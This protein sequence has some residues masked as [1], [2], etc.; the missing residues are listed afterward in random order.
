MFLKKTN[1]FKLKKVKIGLKP[2][3]YFSSTI[4]NDNYFVELSMKEFESYYKSKQERISNF[5]NEIGTKFYSERNIESY[6]KKKD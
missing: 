3:R 6:K 4:N 2:F 5:A 1:F